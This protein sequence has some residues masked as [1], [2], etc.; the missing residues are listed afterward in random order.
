M[1]PYMK[2]K[3][4]V[5]P[6]QFFPLL[7]RE[8]TVPGLCETQLLYPGKNCV[9]HSVWGYTVFSLNIR[10][11]AIVFHIAQAQLF[12]LIIRGKTV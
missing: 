8:I 3:N 12:P 6:T 2:G 9:P 4:C 11:I 1:I 5:P 10:D 7:L